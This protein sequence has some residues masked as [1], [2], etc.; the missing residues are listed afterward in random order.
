MSE[1]SFGASVP[2]NE[3]HSIF[4]VYTLNEMLCFRQFFVSA[5]DKNAMFEATV[6]LCQ[7]LN[8][9]CG[10]HSIC[11]CCLQTCLMFVATIA[12][13]F[14]PAPIVVSQGL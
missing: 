5:Y 13:G 11:P 12:E 9:V 6:S 8:H 10:K 7:L 2:F 14:R 4:V 1:Y 3:L